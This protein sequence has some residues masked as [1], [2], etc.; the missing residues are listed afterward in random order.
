MVNITAS[1]GAANIALYRQH[2]AGEATSATR[3]LQT[4]AR[5]RKNILIEESNQTASTA[6]A[7]RTEADQISTR[8]RIIDIYA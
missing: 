7:L 4:N 8:G 1:V 2:L 5:M 3:S 6:K